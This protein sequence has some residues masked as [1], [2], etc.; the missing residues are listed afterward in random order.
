MNVLLANMKSAL[1]YQL[2]I[3]K[4]EDSSLAMWSVE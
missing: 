3:T 2:D 4:V 1:V